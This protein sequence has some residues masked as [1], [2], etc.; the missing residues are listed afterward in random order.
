MSPKHLRTT[1][2]YYA[3]SVDSAISIDCA[4]SIE[5]CS[6]SAQDVQFHQ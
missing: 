3:M 2:V 1:A 4:M 6:V 5:Y